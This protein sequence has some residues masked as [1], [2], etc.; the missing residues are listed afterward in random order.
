M[1]NFQ[2]NNWHNVAGI[3]PCNDLQIEDWLCTK[4]PAKSADIY[5]IG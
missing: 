2:G 5:I 3:V 1:S 4:N